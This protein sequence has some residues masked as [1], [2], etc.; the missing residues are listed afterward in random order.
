MALRLLEGIARARPAAGPGEGLA[1]RRAIRRALPAMGYLLP[2]LVALMLAG[3]A[4]EAWV[5]L[6]G[7]R[8]YLVPAPSNVLDRLFGD[9]GFFAKE[10][11]V[12]LTGALAGFGL[13]A[14][15]SIALAI[16]MAHSRPVERGIF[17]LAILVKVTPIVAVA[18]LFS[19]WF[20]FSTWPKIIIAAFL[21]FFPVLVNAVVGFRSVSPGALDFA[22]SLQAS[23]REVFWHLRAPSS[24]PYLFA[25]FRITIPLS[26]I[27]AVVAEW[28]TGSSGLGRVI[29]VANGNL[30]TNTVFSA[31]ITLAVIGI[32]LTTVTTVIERR[33]VFWHE[34]SLAQ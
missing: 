12:T 6:A 3:V 17:P 33:L 16:A 26:V 27:G 25:A 34:S 7:I 13:G 2:P 10:G 23:R 8:D 15:V 1:W 19:I 24:L 14:A 29:F 22:R 31:I 20:G 32:G 28:F 4:V 21:T 30:D 9:L 11:A 18:P 5:R